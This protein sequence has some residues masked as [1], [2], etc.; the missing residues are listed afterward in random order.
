MCF[1][2]YLQTQRDTHKH[3]LSLAGLSHWVVC[4]ANVYDLNQANP[5]GLLWRIE[6]DSQD[7]ATEPKREKE[8]E[9]SEEILGLRLKSLFDETVTLVSPSALSPS[10]S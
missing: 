2:V 3:T 8:R 4:A 1:S 7:A 5:T 9:K 10:P 6:D